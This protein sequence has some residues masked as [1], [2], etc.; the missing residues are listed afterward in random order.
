MCWGFRTKC[1]R[2]RWD[3]WYSYLN[4]SSFIMDNNQ[5]RCGTFFQWEHDI[6]YSRETTQP[7][8]IRIEQVPYRPAST[9]PST[10]SL[11]L[12]LARAPA[13][14]LASSER[15]AARPSQPSPVPS[16]FPSLPFPF[17]PPPPLFCSCGIWWFCIVLHQGR[18]NPLGGRCWTGG[19]ISVPWR[20]YLLEGF[21]RLFQLC[22]LALS[23]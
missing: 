3:N 13:E 6:V 14:G 2:R 19:R 8:L 15:A 5:I 23:I 9:P 12:P 21:T 17:L 10:L 22:S 11:P 16:P 7:H 1:K 18:P 20:H 4:I